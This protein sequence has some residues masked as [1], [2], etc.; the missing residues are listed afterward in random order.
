[1]IRAADTDGDGYIHFDGM[2]LFAS[3]HAHFLYTASATTV[4]Q[5]SARCVLFVRF[6][7]AFGS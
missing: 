6:L 2:Q 3:P 4:T 5:I 1:M 7:R